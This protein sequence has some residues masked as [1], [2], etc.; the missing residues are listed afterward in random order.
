M[1]DQVR[2]GEEHGRVG[3]EPAEVELQPRARWGRRGLGPG[4]QRVALGVSSGSVVQDQVQAFAQKAPSSGMS[5]AAV[6][7]EAGSRVSPNVS[8]SIAL[9]LFAR[10]LLTHLR[11][12]NHGEYF[13]RNH[14]SQVTLW[15]QELVEMKRSTRA[16]EF[17]CETHAKLNV[18]MMK[19]YTVFECST[20]QDYL[21]TIILEIKLSMCEAVATLCWSSGQRAHSWS[22]EA[23]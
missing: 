6:G 12:F 9:G 13:L 18:K 16:E 1:D 4:A 7:V 3:L 21:H 11:P 19:A 14:G 8:P 17:C 2:P 20:L 23:S 10:D 5:A 15:L 22:C